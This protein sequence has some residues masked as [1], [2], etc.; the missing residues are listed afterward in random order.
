MC[1]RQPQAGFLNSTRKQRPSENR[2][3][4]F[5]TAFL[6][7]TQPLSLVQAVHIIHFFAAAQNHGD[8]LMQA[9]GADA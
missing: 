5:Q 4:R 1:D 7:L 9:F 3:S 2:F 8:A 6:C